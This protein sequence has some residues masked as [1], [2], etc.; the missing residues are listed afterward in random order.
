MNPHPLYN[1]KISSLRQW[2]LTFALVCIILG[3]ALMKASSQAPALQP[4]KQQAEHLE[5]LQLK[6]QLAYQNFQTAVG[7]LTAA[8]REVIKENKWPETTTCN[9]DA[10]PITFVSSPPATP[11]AP[12]KEEKK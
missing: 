10:Q 5:L 8:C 1:E 6:A 9:L 3:L 7:N 2:L 4:S 11:P 12:K